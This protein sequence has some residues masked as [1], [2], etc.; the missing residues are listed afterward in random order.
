[1]KSQFFYARVAVI[2]TSILLINTI[3]A[4]VLPWEN[5]S[6]YLP[7]KMPEI[8]RQLRGI[9]IC[10]VINLDWPSKEVI[11]I[12]DDK[13]R[14]EKSKDELIDILDNA[15]EMNLNSVFFQVSPEGDAFY[16]SDIVPWSRYLTG[17]FGK[18]PG[19][20][21]LEFAIKEARKRNLEFHAW[22]NPYRISMY[23]GIETIKTLDIE[24]SV[25]KQHPEW[26]RTGMG[27]FIVDPGIPEARQWVIDRVI[28]VTQKYD[29]DGIHF[30]DYF[31]YEKDFGEIN[32]KETYYNY[33]KGEFSNIE[34]WRRNN[35]YLLVKEVSQKI[36]ELKP[37]VK[38]GISPS[39]VWGN[40][41]DGHVEG[42]N[43]N[44]D[45]TNYEKCFANT[46]KWVEEEIIDYI[47]PQVYFTF[48]NPN[49]SYGEVASWWSNL[50]EGKNVHLYIGQ[51]LYSINDSYDKYFNGENAVLEFSNQ[52][53]FNTFNTGI[54]GSIMFRAK[55]F[56][57]EC[58][59]DV[60]NAIKT[61]LWPKKVLVPIMPWKQGITPKTPTQGN[62]EKVSNGNKLT[63]FDY[64]LNTSYYA[65]Y[66]VG[67]EEF[68]DIGPNQ[69]S[70]K[71]IDIVIKKTG[72]YQEFVDTTKIS[73]EN[74]FYVVTALD[75][76]HN[77]SLGL[78]ISKS[79]S[80]YFNDV[81][82]EYSW[83]V[84]DIDA[85]FERNI[86]KGVG[87]SKFSP[88]D[89]TKRG[90]FVLMIVRALNLQAEFADNFKD[91]SQES[92]YYDAVGISK[93]LGIAKGSGENFN[94]EGN[95]TR[96]DMTVIMVRALKAYG[97][98][99]QSAGEEYLKGYNDEHMISDYAKN[100]VATLTKLGVIKGYDSKVHPK[101]LA[102]RAEIVVMLNRVLAKVIQ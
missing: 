58:K 78:K 62:L 69:T 57:D 70:K 72:N 101:D 79:I 40:K 19:F 80:R 82:K 27:R 43:T 95:I 52:I 2:L 71:L 49:A 25:Y 99:I 76:L 7:E 85:F 77:E 12:K 93:K 34:D 9:W 102:T 42:S 60:V 16:K 24:K 84:R 48:A 1:M 61:D 32:D 73:N 29:V 4:N 46:K 68:A 94:P 87:Q 90:D 47:A 31:Y 23:T 88:G 65:V 56:E 55:S 75:R 35:T 45:Y 8:T 44:T 36:K 20:D 54:D 15:V 50:C 64:D 81:G 59:R 30:D 74:V 67:N 41:K 33:N 21:P 83:A 96:E 11:D 13:E 5:Y 6:K 3:S 63:W 28:E 89:N 100:A 51:A 39:G 37:W 22:I 66:R 86:I 53:K 92:Y 98:E 26:I 10:T 38:F 14:I 17:T 97:V 91:V 18:D